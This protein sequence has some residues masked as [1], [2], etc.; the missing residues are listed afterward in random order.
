MFKI[1]NKHDNELMRRERERERERETVSL[2]TL[3]SF[4]FVTNDLLDHDNAGLKKTISMA[5]SLSQYHKNN[6]KMAKHF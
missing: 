1:S 2:R 6:G 4:V 3:S 5:P